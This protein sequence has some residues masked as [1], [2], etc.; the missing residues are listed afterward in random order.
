MDGLSRTGNSGC[1]T[2]ASRP[3]FNPER[4]AVKGQ[5]YA[6]DMLQVRKTYAKKRFTPFMV[7]ASI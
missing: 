4:Q 2:R 6:C 5:I 3:R 7:A 1:L